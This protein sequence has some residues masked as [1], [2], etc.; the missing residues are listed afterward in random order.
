MPKRYLHDR[1][2]T[3]EINTLRVIH[4]CALELLDGNGFF[5][6]IAVANY[7]DAHFTVIPLWNNT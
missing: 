7:S 4:C 2:F 6:A 5:R 3:L 1:A